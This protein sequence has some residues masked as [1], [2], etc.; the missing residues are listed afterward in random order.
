MSNAADC[1]RE[2]RKAVGLSVHHCRA[3]P[4]EY[5]QENVSEQR[6]KA[7]WDG[8]EMVLLAREEL[9]AEAEGVK[10]MNKHLHSLFP[11]QT[12]IPSKVNGG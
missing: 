6:K 10:K 9:C 11:S 8:E 2:F 3:H 7:R 1:S 12:M 5:H 4:E